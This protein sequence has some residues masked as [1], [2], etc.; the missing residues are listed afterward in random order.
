LEEELKRTRGCGYSLDDEEDVVGIRCIGVVLFDYTGR[1]IGAISISAQAFDLP[2]DSVQLLVPRLRA[3]GKQ[4]S[5]AMGAAP[6]L[7]ALYDVAED[8]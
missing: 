4:A 7:L 3:A 1:A 8:V 2:L 5:A 6:D